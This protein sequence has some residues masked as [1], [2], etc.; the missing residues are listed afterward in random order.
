M[1]TVKW[2]FEDKQVLCNKN[3]QMTIIKKEGK[4]DEGKKPGLHSLNV[5]TTYIT[6]LASLFKH[7]NLQTTQE[8]ACLK[9]GNKS[10]TKT[11]QGYTGYSAWT[12]KNHTLVKRASSH[13]L[14]CLKN[15]YKYS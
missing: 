7:A 12:V 1:E 14:L 2:H 9:Q 3:E 6:S 5:L 13:Y 8:E 11:I 10:Q 4:E 15:I